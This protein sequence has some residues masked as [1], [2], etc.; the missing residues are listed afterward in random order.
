MK[1]SALSNDSTASGTVNELRSNTL[2][3]EQV[4]YN[5]EQ[6]YLVAKDTNLAQGMYLGR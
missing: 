4:P 5:S 3:Q 2:V 1:N 6:S